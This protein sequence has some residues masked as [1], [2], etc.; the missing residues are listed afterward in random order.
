MR[1]FLQRQLLDNIVLDYLE[2]AAAI[3]LIIIIRRIISRYLAQLLNK[4]FGAKEKKL[5]RQSPTQ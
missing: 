4:S 2:V 3:L 5:Q 1:E